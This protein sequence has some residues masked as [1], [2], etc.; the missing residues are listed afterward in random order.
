[1]SPTEITAALKAFLLAELGDEDPFIVGHVM[2]AHAV[3]FMA[4]FVGRR[5]AAV[6]L[7]NFAAMVVANC[8]GEDLADRLLAQ[9]L[10]ARH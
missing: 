5:T 10:Q 3:D 7:G 9:T 2:A 1:M 8:D 4:P 6:G